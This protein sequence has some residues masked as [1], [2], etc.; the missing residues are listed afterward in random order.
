RSKLHAIVISLLARRHAGDL[1]AGAHDRADER[2][3]ERFPVGIAEGDVGGV[4]SGRLDAHDRLAGRIVHPDPARR[5]APD[6]A[7]YVALHAIGHAALGARIAVKDARPRHRAVG[8]DVVGAD[9]ALAAAVDVEDLLVGREAKPVGIDVVLAHDA[10]AAAV[11]RDA[12]Y[13]LDLQVALDV[14]AHHPDVEK[15]ARR[16]GEPDRAVGFHHDVVRAVELHALPALGE[17]L[18]CAVL[19]APEHRAPTPAGDEQPAFA[20]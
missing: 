3:V 7:R 18:P 13:R 20:I 11:G 16:I 1:D 12:E 2:D 17:R 19:L 8:L 5:G 4:M 6:V 9:H 15:P 14:G 10:H